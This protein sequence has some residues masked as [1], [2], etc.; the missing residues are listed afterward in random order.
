MRA[1]NDAFQVVLEVLGLA[2]LAYW[3]WQEGTDF[4]RWILAIGVPLA[5]AIVW[6]TLV[7]KVSATKLD[8]PS[9]LRLELVIVIAAS[10]GL[11]RV[12]HLVWAVAFASLALLQLSLTYVLHQR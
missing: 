7:S 3:G 12:G 1:L 6:A 2:S 8:D 4:S 9:R 10:A 11:A 5:F